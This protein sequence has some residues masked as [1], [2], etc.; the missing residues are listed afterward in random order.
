M[1]GRLWNMIS[2][3]LFIPFYIQAMGVKLYGLIGFFAVLQGLMAVADLG[4][5]ATLQ[6]EFAIDHPNGKKLRL[7]RAAE[8]IYLL[9]AL[10]AGAGFYFFAGSIGE[11]WLNTEGIDPAT[12]LS[13]VRY[14]GIAVCLQVLSTIYT[15]ALLGLEKQVLA[16]GLQMAWGLLKSGLV[17]PV[18]FAVSRPA[19][20]FFLWQIGA[21]IVFLAALRMMLSKAL[22]RGQ[23]SEPAQGKDELFR[24][25]LRFAGNIIVLGL[26]TGIIVQ[27]D[28]LAVS[29]YLPI[30]DFSIYTLAGALAAVPVVVA[31]PLAVAVYP[32]L[33]KAMARKDAATTHKVFEQMYRLIAIAAAVVAVNIALYSELLLEL[34]TKKPLIAGKGGRVT[35]VLVL[36]QMCLAQQVIPYYLAL[37]A[38]KMKINIVLSAIGLATL[39]LLYWWIGS[40]SSLMVMAAV[41]TVYHVLFSMVYILLVVR[42]FTSINPVNFL[43]RSSLLPVLGVIAAACP[44]YLLKPELGHWS[45]DLIYVSISSVAGFLVSAGLCFRLPPHRIPAYLRKDLL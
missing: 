40:G 41:I 6:R 16:N 23:H 32:K 29:K 21:N 39:A 13:C 20:T 37:A 27:I 14:M 22:G 3:Y 15:G 38:G 43:F 5:S 18:L 7:L 10:I 4:F 35:A 8:S 12:T 2:I 31:N 9:I 26:I 25:S 11:R 1:A 42:R 34:W 19:E 17:I 33:T 36:G 45:L 44:T 28:K 30:D 24:R